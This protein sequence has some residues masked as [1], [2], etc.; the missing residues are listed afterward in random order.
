VD[1][2]GVGAQQGVSG[3]ALATEAVVDEEAED[4]LALRGEHARE[5]LHRLCVDERR[6]VR[7]IRVRRRE[8]ARGGAVRERGRRHLRPAGEDLRRRRAGR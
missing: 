1:L 4:V 3:I 8:L 2:H 6:Q 5:A 7:A